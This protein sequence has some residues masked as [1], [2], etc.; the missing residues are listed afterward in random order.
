[1]WFL[2][3]E[4]KFLLSVG[5]IGLVNWVMFGVFVWRLTGSFVVFVDVFELL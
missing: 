4:F 2:S 3:L 5:E 1:M